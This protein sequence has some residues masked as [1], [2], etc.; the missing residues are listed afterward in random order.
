MA[1]SVGTAA[2]DFTLTTLG[3]NGHRCQVQKDDF[4]ANWQETEV[5]TADPK[6]KTNY[7][8]LHYVQHFVRDHPLIMRPGQIY[9]LAVSFEPDVTMVEG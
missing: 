5:V 8:K 3:A 1:L 7:G 2:P 4:H 9:R 6:Y